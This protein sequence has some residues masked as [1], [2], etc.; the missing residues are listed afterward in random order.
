MC[1]CA[2]KYTLI[3]VCACTSAC[4]YS[5]LRSRRWRD[6]RVDDRWTVDGRPN[7]PPPP[8]PPPPPLYPLSRPQLL[9]ANNLIGLDLL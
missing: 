8:P 9:C 5:A 6:C 4:R 3:S 7:G 2:S 1:V